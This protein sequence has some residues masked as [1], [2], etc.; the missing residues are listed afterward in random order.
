MHRFHI[1]KNEGE[2]DIY[3]DIIIG[4]N[5]MV[6]VGLLAKFMNKVLRWGGV[7]VPMKEPSGLIGK[8]YLTILD[9][10]EVVMQTEEPFLTR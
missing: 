6:Q 3:Y 7:T 4:S 1:D 2:S 5:M 9:M 10:H 8:S